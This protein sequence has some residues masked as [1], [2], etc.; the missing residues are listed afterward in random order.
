VDIALGAD[1]GPEDFGLADTA[2]SGGTAVVDRVVVSADIAVA[3]DTVAAVDT[4]SD[5]E[6]SWELLPN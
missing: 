1:T 3:A 6:Q 2:A 5:L 4:D